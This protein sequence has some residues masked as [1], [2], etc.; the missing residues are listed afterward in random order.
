MLH[1]VSV[2]N[3]VILKQ[4][5]KITLAYKNRNIDTW[6]VLNIAQVYPA[7]L[8]KK[9]HWNRGYTWTL[10]TL[11]KVYSTVFL[12]YIWLATNISKIIIFATM[13]LPF[14]ACSERNC[15][16]ANPIVLCWSYISNRKW[17]KDY[18]WHTVFILKN[19][20]FHLINNQFVLSLCKLLQNAIN[21]ST[22]A[23][24]QS[25]NGHTIE[26][27][28]NIKSGIFVIK[29]KLFLKKI[30]LKCFS[31]FEISTE[32]MILST[33]DLLLILLI[34]IKTTTRTKFKTY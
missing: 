29:V 2:F 20:Y 11:I 25:G 31:K 24:L 12:L 16:L 1:N 8:S 33:F 15:M 32:Y 14:M 27:W 23:F 26:I 4:R 19:R 10:F 6:T 34:N 7:R 3:V 18:L 17:F 21:K 9:C 13:L 22:K 5:R 30:D 28:F